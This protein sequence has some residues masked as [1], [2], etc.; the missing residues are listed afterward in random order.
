M[1][2]AHVLA[3]VARLLTDAGVD[4]LL[5]KGAALALTVYEEPAARLMSDIDML[6]REG[7]SD[8]VVAALVAGGC[9]V[10]PEPGRRYSAPLLGETGVFVRAGAMTELVEVHTTLDKV[11]TRPIDMASLFARAAP[12]PALPGLFVPAAEDHALL[13]ALHAASHDFAHPV[14]FLDLELL[15]RRGLDA[16]VLVDRAREWR[17]SAVMFAMLSAMR[18]LGAASVD[19]ALV[20]AFDPGPLRRAILGGKAARGVSRPGLG[21]IVAQTP[22]RDDPLKWIVGVGRYAVARARDR[23]SLLAQGTTAK[24]DAAVPYRVPL[25]VRA[26]VALDRTA[27]RM[28]SVRAGIRDEALLAWIPAAERASLTTSIYE[29]QRTYFPGGIRFDGGL[30][31]WELR[32]LAS[33]RFPRSGRVLLGAAGAGRELVALVDR[34]FEVVAFDPCEP[35]ADAA[36]SI[37][38]RDKA[39]VIH[40]S[41]DDLIAAAA[42]RG[43]PL[44]DA[45]KGKPFDAVIL[46]WASLSHV[47][48]SSARVDLFRALRVL[49]PDAPVLA[50]FGLTSD[51]GTPA[52]GKGRVRRT[53]RR[54]FA[55]LGAKGVAEDTDHF[56]S[57]IGF[58]AYLSHEEVRDLASRSGYEIALFEDTP[59]AYALL[60]PALPAKGTGGREGV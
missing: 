29:E 28:E 3:K 57:H 32:V 35:F 9:E 49:A 24:Q 55:A 17:L 20:A 16:R 22:L 50:S 33:P 37:A 14:G 56:F 8:R 30:F 26:L 58:F 39:N 6:V 27:A 10:R 21:W 45:V 1:F 48:P 2:R 4:A 7:E 25:W 12:A 38:P 5:V 51:P 18:Q 15:L 34:G 53:L 11:V 40:A 41:Y 19:D 36:R 52:A 46:G 31:T 43:G 23:R 54:V 44:A 60:V 47:M 13:I 42:G 59:Y